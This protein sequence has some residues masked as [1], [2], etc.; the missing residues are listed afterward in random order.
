[1]LRKI[2]D[3]AVPFARDGVIAASVLGQADCAERLLHF[4]RKRA[5]QILADAEQQVDALHAQAHQ[6]GYREGMAEALTAAVPRL[7]E[8]LADETRV[9]V[10]VRQEMEARIRETLTEAG[11]EAALVAQCC[12]AEASEPGVEGAWTLYVPEDRRELLERLEAQVAQGVLRVRPGEVPNPVLERA[13]RV[14]ELNT[15]ELA[16]R[17]LSSWLDEYALGEAL[18]E[19]ACDYAADVERAIKISAVRSGLTHLNTED[20][21][22]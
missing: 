4:A 3:S 18:R 2:P 5:A 21:D 14:I 8:L 19:R 10:L 6:A 1:M 9:K 22:Q 13:D 16:M 11:I 15:T 7:A 12:L 20:D 17:Q